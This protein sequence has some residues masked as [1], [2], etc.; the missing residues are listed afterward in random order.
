M[1]GVF[2]RRIQRTGL[3]LANAERFFLEMISSRFCKR[4]Y[5]PN[6]SKNRVLEERLGDEVLS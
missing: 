2:Y 5:L 3:I 4:D 1:L 6:K